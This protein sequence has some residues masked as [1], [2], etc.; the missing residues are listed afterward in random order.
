MIGK[1]TLYLLFFAGIATHAARADTYCDV[2]MVDWHPIPEL[3]AHL[4][5]SDWIVQEVEIEDGC[6]EVEGINAEGRHVEILFDPQTF[7]MIKF[8]IED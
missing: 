3:V 8:E 4:E 7:A 5:A 2:P 6:Y 1:L